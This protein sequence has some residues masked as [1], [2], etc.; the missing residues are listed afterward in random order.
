MLRLTYFQPR[1]RSCAAVAPLV[2]L[3]AS[4]IPPRWLRYAI[5]PIRA[6]SNSAPRPRTR[7]LI[8]AATRAI[9]LLVGDGVAIR[10]AR[11]HRGRP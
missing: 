11:Q 4:Y 8:R 5:K 6:L 2:A 1:A 7:P 10:V 9:D 3:A